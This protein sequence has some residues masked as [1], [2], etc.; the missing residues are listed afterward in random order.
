MASL[1]MKTVAGAGV[2]WEV[3]CSSLTASAYLTIMSLWNIQCLGRRQWSQGIW[4][5]SH[6]SGYKRLLQE[7]GSSQLT[8]LIGP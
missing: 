7:V 6:F 4:R 8:T 2:S 3:P 1:G 5:A